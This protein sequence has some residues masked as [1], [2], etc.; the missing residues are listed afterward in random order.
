MIIL[1][2]ANLP[3]NAAKYSVAQTPRHA[4]TQLTGKKIGFLGSSITI[5]AGSLNES[6]VDFLTAE[7]GII[8][9]ESAI[10]GTTLAGPA[11]D[12]YI[13]RLHSDFKNVTSLDAFV[14]Q[15]STNDDRQGKAVGQ[16][17]DAFDSGS[18]DTT[19][20]TGALEEICAEVTARYHC[21]ILC[22]TCLRDPQETDYAALIQQLYRLQAK[23]HFQILDLW[24]DE[25]VK[26]ATAAQPMAMM[27][28]AHPT[29]FG[30]REIWTPRFEAAL[31]ALMS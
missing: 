4:A 14:C 22:Y 19:T 24:A 15:L 11:S 8:P 26:Q 9:A 28:D 21:P 31:T 20:T 17:T 1:E 7:V 13:E 6:F 10:S 23:W 2:I 18:F 5:G 3:G 30:Y 12:S 29:R 16:I 25:Q 27:D